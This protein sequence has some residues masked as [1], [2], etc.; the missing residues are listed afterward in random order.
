MIFEIDLVVARCPEV[1]V[2]LD[3]DIP[4]MAELADVQ[5]S[6]SGSYK[7]ELH[8]IAYHWPI[9]G[10]TVSARW[11]ER[12]QIWIRCRRWPTKAKIAELRG[13]TFPYHFIDHEPLEFSTILLKNTVSSLSR[14]D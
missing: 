14:G 7:R 4:E 2:C 1:F 9:R 5:F 10:W 13:L 12:S 11:D 3:R 6:M 8:A